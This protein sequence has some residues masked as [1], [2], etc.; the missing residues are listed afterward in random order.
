MKQKSDAKT[1]NRI[2]W[3]TDTYVDHNGVSMVLQAMHK[4]I[5]LRN[6]P[7]DILVCSDSLE[8]DDH[9]IVL[10]PISEFNIPMY[11]QQPLRIPNFLSIRRIFSEGK[12]DRVLCSTEGPMGLAAM[13]LKKFYSVKTYFYLHTDWIMFAKQVMGFK[14]AGLNHLQR[15]IRMYY[16]RFD[17]IFVLNTDQQRWLTGDSMRFDPS[18]VLM[19]AHWTEDIF[20]RKKTDMLNDLEILK[21]PPV[22]LYT[23]RLS[24]EK[25]IFELP[26]I[27]RLAKE[28]IPDLRMLIAGTGP[29]E[30][31]LRSAFPEAE[32]TGWVD[33]DKLPEVYAQADL[34]I[35]PS[36]FDTFSCVVLEALSCGVP[37]I[38][39]NTKGPKDIIRNSVDGFLAETSMEMSGHIVRFFSDDLLRI[40]L[41]KGALVRAEDYSSDKILRDMLNDLEICTSEQFHEVKTA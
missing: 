36:R 22:L 32:Y 41:K 7:I 34:L 21:K 33:H 20:L 12:Y 6:L 27:Y 31:E 24:P 29:S 13:Y 25:G 2:L 14:E 37:V 26:S 1:L 11:R 3:L 30:Q 35:L 40:E 10:R 18:R 9:L 5:K 16:K 4:E 19:T 8:P 23:G 38:A 15:L 39:Y 28:F 17:Y